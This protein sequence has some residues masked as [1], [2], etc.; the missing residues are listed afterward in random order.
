MAVFFAIMSGVGTAVGAFLGYAVG[1]AVGLKDGTA[2]GQEKTRDTFE[3]VLAIARMQTLAH[4]NGGS[5]L[6]DLVMSLFN[7]TK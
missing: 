7:E 4:E 3:R 2:A 6:A 5:E 1:Y